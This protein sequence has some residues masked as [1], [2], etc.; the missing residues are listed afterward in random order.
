MVLNIQGGLIYS[1]NKKYY[2]IETNKFYCESSTSMHSTD[3]LFLNNLYDKDIS[4][5]GILKIN[6]NNDTFELFPSK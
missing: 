3:Y 5:R 6:K 4:K 1:N 2:N